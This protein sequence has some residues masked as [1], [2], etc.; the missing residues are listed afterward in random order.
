ML[1]RL[2]LCKRGKNAKKVVSFPTITSIGPHFYYKCI[3]SRSAGDPGQNDKGQSITIE[4]ENQTAQYITII[5]GFIK[6][7]SGTCRSQPFSSLLQQDFAL[8]RRTGKGRKRLEHDLY[9]RRNSKR[10]SHPF[11]WSC[12]H[13][14]APMGIEKGEEHKFKFKTFHPFLPTSTCSFLLLEHK[15]HVFAP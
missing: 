9:R 15:E 13:S 3:P 14:R 1:G 12:N 7:V 2:I 11:C 6:A 8:K 5:A 10:I 4:D